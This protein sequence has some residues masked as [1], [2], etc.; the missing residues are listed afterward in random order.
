MP[1]S[2]QAE[3]FGQIDQTTN[4]SDFNAITFLVSQMLAKV[5]T[6]T[7][8]QVKG[9]TN[10]GALS[11]VGFVDVQPMVNQMTGDRKAVSHGTIYH[12][13]YFRL[14][15]GGNAVILDPQVGDIGMAG[16]CSRD[17]SSVKK[18]KA[19]ANPGSFRTF[20]FADGLYI[21]GM[22]NG[23][24]TQYVQFSSA[25][26]KLH[27]PALINLDAPDVQINAQTVEI[28]ASTSATFTTPTLTVNGNVQTN[29]T[30]GATGNITG[31]GIS[32]DTHVHPVPGGGN[33]GAPI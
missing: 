32:L 12:L 25:G 10:A 30:I 33:T 16:F 26:I 18:A 6:V 27:S 3:A 29:G 15:G 11:P 8:V 28:N 7:L 22:L 24:P 21:G 1:Q 2:S 4:T 23:T 17:I 13:P 14:Q 31:G 20:D 9:V 19:P 5:Q